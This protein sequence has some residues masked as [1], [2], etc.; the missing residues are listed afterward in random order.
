MKGGR[1]TERRREQ[2]Y[3][4]SIEVVVHPL[5][6]LESVAPCDSTTFSGRIQNISRSGLCITTSGAITLSSVIR[7]EIPVCDAEVCVATLM[8]VRWTRKRSQD[9][10][11]F[12]SGLEALL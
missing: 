12:I 6:E 9:P 4:Q 8:R 5:P 1:Q 7:C 2:R 3:P 11:G 10:N